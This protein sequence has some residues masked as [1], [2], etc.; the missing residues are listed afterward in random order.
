MKQVKQEVVI[1]LK[2]VTSFIRR[3]TIV[4]KRVKATSYDRLYKLI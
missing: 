2:Q 4:M 1:R 3:E